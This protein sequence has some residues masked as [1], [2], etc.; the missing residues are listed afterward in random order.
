MQRRI[1]KTIERES[2]KPQAGCAVTADPQESFASP[3]SLRLPEL[4]EQLN[5]FDKMG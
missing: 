2:V 1:I 4:W 3:T 5:Y